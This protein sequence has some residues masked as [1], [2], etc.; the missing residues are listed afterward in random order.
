LEQLEILEKSFSN[1]TEKMALE[2]G[3][4]RRTLRNWIVEFSKLR[5]FAG[6]PHVRK[7]VTE[8]RT[9]YPQMEDKLRRWIL[10][11][12]LKRHPI[13]FKQ[14]INQATVFANDLP[15]AQTFVASN[16]WFD[17]FIQR[18]NTSHRRATKKSAENNKSQLVKSQ[19]I[20]GYLTALASLLHIFPPHMILNMDE[21]PASIDL[22]RGVTYD[23]VGNKTIDIANTGT[24][25]DCHTVTLT[26]AADGTRLP[27]YVIF[28]RL[29]KCPNVIHTKNLV[30]TTS[31]SGL[32][33][34]LFC[35]L[36]V[37]SFSFWC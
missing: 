34:T 14:I 30:L 12:R 3:I 18:A 25:K 13:S 11:K 2:T 17:N 35:I 22:E 27:T 9:K 37:S 10:E 16:G 4:P 32:K 36:R 8:P 15:Q 31:D 28:K 29:K 6:S 19:Q 7:I 33:F 5:T 26:I 23:F 20:T 24:E 1:N 21:T